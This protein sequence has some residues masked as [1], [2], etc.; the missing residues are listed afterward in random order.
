LLFV[1]K[2]SV[3]QVF[4]SSSE[5]SSCSFLSSK[6]FFHGPI[7]FLFFAI[8]LFG[9][10]TSFCFRKKPISGC[11]SSFV[12]IILF[13]LLNSYSILMCSQMISSSIKLIQIY[14]LLCSKT[15]VLLIH[16]SSIEI[17]VQ[18]IGF[19]VREIVSLFW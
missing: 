18:W 1:L 10:T 12:K 6:K 19:L 9:S 14:L 11:S 7:L 4:H 13:E 15:K 2:G 8:S 16:I 3:C 17:S 5:L